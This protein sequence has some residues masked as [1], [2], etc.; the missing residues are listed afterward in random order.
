MGG[1]LFN[2]LPLLNHSGVEFTTWLNALSGL[3]LRA[4]QCYGNKPPGPWKKVG[5]AYI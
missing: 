1:D 3:V 5:N 2:V 4:H